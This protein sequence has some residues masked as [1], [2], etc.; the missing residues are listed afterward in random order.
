M[1]DRFLCG[2]NETNCQGGRTAVS[3]GIRTT[4][5]FRKTHSS[6]IEAFKCMVNNLKQLGY[7]Q[8]GPREFQ[9]PEDGCILV[10]TK[11]SRFGQRLRSGK[12]ANRHM[13]KKRH[14]GGIT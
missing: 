14:G 2:V 4:T 3:A 7:T 1:A 8:V 10:L 6:N 12:E 5:E 9:E 11:K 13:P